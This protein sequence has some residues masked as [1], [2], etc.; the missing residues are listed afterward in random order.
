MTSF[1]SNTRVRGAFLRGFAD[2]MCIAGGPS[3]GRRITPDTI[4][5]FSF[6]P[7]D[8]SSDIENLRGDSMKAIENAQRSIET[9]KRK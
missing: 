7:R 6:S 3:S 5:N 2:G 4:K 8:P 9:L 1:F